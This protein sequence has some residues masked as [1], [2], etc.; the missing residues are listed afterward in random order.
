MESKEP[1]LGHNLIFQLLTAYEQ[2]LF[3]YNLIFRLLQFLGLL[4][5]GWKESRIRI[6]KAKNDVKHLQLLAT[7]PTYVGNYLQY[8]P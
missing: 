7:V 1:D 2:N 8:I 4:R 3:K 6:G 5:I